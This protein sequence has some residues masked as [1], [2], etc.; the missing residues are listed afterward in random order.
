MISFHLMF[1]NNFLH[2]IA[3]QTHIEFTV[4]YQIVVVIDHRFV[5]LLLP[6]VRIT[7]KII[8]SINMVAFQVKPPQKRYIEPGFSLRVLSCV[9]QI[10]SFKLINFKL[11]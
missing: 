2:L 9:L 4:F 3:F 10:A 11:Q 7:V 6:I 5:V 8:I 1:Y